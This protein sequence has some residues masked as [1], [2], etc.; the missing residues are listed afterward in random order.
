MK[1]ILTIIAL[2]SLLLFPVAFAEDVSVDQ[3]KQMMT[4]SADDLTS[5]YLLPL[6]RKH[7]YLQQ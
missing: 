5:L 2:I 3:L 1:I 4:K 7:Y 6:C